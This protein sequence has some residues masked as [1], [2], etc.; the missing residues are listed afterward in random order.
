MVRTGALITI[1]ALFPLRAWAQPQLRR[2]GEQELSAA[3]VR[4]LASQALTEVLPQGVELLA[5]TWSQSIR[6]PR[7]ELTL[8]AQL[9]SEE[10]RRGRL[11]ARLELLVDQV[12]QRVIPLA[13]RVRDRR[14]VAVVTRRLQPGETID[15][16]AVELRE[17]PGDLAVDQPVRDLDQVMGQVASRPL[18]PGEVLQRRSVRAP[19]AVRR[20]QR[21]RLVARV[22]GVEVVALGEPLQDGAV[23]EVVPVTCLASRRLLRGRVVAPGLVEVQ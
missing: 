10:P 7:G 9:S 1:L 22:G 21:V 16:G 15:P 23:G 14:P 8:E 3:R 13:L 2:R 11:R 5:V 20:R 19:L 18:T 12:T 6:V 17:S 4:Q